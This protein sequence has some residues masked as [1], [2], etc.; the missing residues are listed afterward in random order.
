MNKSIPTTYHCIVCA[1][2]RLYLIQGFSDLPRITSDCRPFSTGGELLVCE[3]CSAVQ[4]RTSSRWLAEINDIYR[5]Y[6]AY[7]LA[8]GEEQ[9]VLDPDTARPAKRSDVIVQSLIKN[10][11]FPNSGRALDVGCGHGVTLSALSTVLTEW[12]LNGY[13]LS[14]GNVS[15]LKKIKNFQHLYTGELTSINEK[16]DLV[17]MIHSLEHFVDPIATLCELRRLV[18]QEGRLFIEVCNVEE[19]PFDL[20]VADH[21]L[22]FSPASLKYALSRAG[23]SLEFA[24]TKWVKKEISVIASPGEVENYKGNDSDEINR[25]SACIAWLSKLV[26]LAKAMARD[27]RPF[28]IFGTSIAATW[29]ATALAE[30]VDFF[31]DEDPNRIG[32]NYMGKKV[33]GPNEVPRK[34]VVFLALAPALAESISHRLINYQFKLISPPSI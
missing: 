32:Q 31:V 2:P 11:K 1:Q 20:L 29:L 21:L 8:G 18:G 13:E 7:S 6:S 33:I 9:L 27:N 23:F 19:N 34:A 22:H 17:S 16:F 15:T 3:N 30:D 10:F 4:K 25:I 12:K 5:D 28:G 26:D 14:E 24:S